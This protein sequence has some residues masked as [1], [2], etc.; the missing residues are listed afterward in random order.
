MWPALLSLVCE[1]SSLATP[2]IFAASA[3]SPPL[4]VCKCS[5]EQT[6]VVCSLCNVRYHSLLLTHNSCSSRR[7]FLP[8]LLCLSVAYGRRSEP[9]QGG[10]KISL[11]KREGI[12][13]MENTGYPTNTCI[14]CCPKYACSLCATVCLCGWEESQP[15]QGIC[16]P[17]NHSDSNW[18]V[19]EAL[20]QR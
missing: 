20:N 5:S 11:R 7:T 6:P 13:P 3:S 2:V 4:H 1:A 15:S 17:C 10:M 14:L 16:V 9:G 18:F 8:G 12:L 19:T